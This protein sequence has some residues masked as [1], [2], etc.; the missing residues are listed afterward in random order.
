MDIWFE[1]I[2]QSNKKNTV[3]PALDIWCAKKKERINLSYKIES[4]GISEIDWYIDDDGVFDNSRK[5]TQW[6][7][8]GYL[9]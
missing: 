1:R 9:I 4:K 6:D 5:K 3:Y 2:K 7:L 8:R